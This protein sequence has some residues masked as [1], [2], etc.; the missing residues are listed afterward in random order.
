VGDLFAAAVDTIRRAGLPEYRRHHVGH[1]IGLEMYEAPLLV[2]NSD[3]RLEAGM[4]INVETPYYESGYG[5]FQVEDT[6]LVTENGGE[7]LTAADRSLVA[8]GVA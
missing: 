2:E 3:A 6:V 1:G 8:V 4:V 7:L 5:G